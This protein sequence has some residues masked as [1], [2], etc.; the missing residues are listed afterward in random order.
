VFQYMNIHSLNEKTT[1]MEIIMTKDKV[2][3]KERDK[4]M[5]ED[6]FLNAAEKLYADRGYF[7]TSMEDVAQEA[8]YA[9]GTIYRYFASKEEL[10]HKLLI[11]KGNA[12]F[13]MIHGILVGKNTSLDKL[14]AIIHSKVRFFFENAEFMRIYITEVNAPCDTM[15]PPEE[16]EKAHTKYMELLADILRDGMKEG[17]FREMDV[18]ML[19]LAWI[20][21]TNNLL[22][23][24]ISN[25]NKISEEEAEA[26]ILS[27]LGD[28][29]MTTKGNK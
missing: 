13:E 10:Y 2:T 16:L 27:L 4:Q 19:L 28:G 25:E 18:D 9:T 17:V 14:R 15:N 21:M 11:R 23:K 7:Q 20:G 1:H 12:Y 5:R 29:L 6:D 3:R 8:E 22:C 26:F 24:T